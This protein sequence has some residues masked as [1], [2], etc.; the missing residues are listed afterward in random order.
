MV[1]KER[2]KGAYWGKKGG[3][4]KSDRLREGDYCRIGKGIKKESRAR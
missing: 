4:G 3:G 1:R 2:K